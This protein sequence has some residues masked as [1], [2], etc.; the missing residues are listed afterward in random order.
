MSLYEVHT[1]TFRPETGHH[2][3]QNSVTT[4]ATVP[5]TSLFK[6]QAEK[7]GYFSRFLRGSRK[8]YFS[9]AVQG[10]DTD[11]WRTQFQPVGILL[12]FENKIKEHQLHF[13]RVVCSDSIT[14]RSVLLSCKWA[15][16]PSLDTS[17]KYYFRSLTLEIG[18]R[19]LK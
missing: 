18:D 12:D 2:P 19:S 9:V 3:S 13:S 1:Q 5:S 10:Q 7:R 11:F 14:I 4:A 16:H 6:H 15:T 17:A 8:G